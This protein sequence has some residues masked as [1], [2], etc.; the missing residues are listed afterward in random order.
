VALIGGAP[1]GSDD[2]TR[3]TLL[4][5]DGSA[6]VVRARGACGFSA[7]SIRDVAP[8]RRG[9]LL[10]AGSFESGPE[11]AV[12]ARLERDGR[13]VFPYEAPSEQIVPDSIAGVSQDGRVTLRLR[14]P[15]ELPLLRYRDDG[16]VDRTYS[17]S[18]QQTVAEKGMPT[19]RDAA[20]A[21]DGSVALI[22]PPE[23]GFSTVLLLDPDAQ[24][25]AGMPAKPEELERRVGAARPLRDGGALM[26]VDGRSRET[27]ETLRVPPAKLWRL[28]P[29]G[30]LDEG[31]AANTK[32]LA[33]GAGDI[34]VLDTAADGRMLLLVHWY[35][36][37]P[38]AYSWP[39][40]IRNEVIV[41]DRDGR[42]LPRFAA[43]PF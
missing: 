26:T 41:V 13:C 33:P 18:L 9:G 39:W 3:L 36:S 42:R 38:Q 25:V 19:P 20:G 37:P 7:G 35:G 8:D 17:A 32:E 27:A 6:K 15:Q 23:I 10:L 40:P 34:R 1:D 28:L 29:D 2:L 22:F 24:A 5:P 43:P 14:P 21:T 12:L 16:G 30:T 4:S 11:N 31:F